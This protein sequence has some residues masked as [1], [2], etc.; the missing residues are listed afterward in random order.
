MG[1][2]YSARGTR[3]GLLLAGVAGLL[4]VAWAAGYLQGVAGSGQVHQAKVV[5]R[6]LCQGRC[7]QG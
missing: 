5:T 4:W 6:S 7:V 2:W 1:R 3:R